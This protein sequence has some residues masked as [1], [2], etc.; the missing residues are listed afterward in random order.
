MEKKWRQFWSIRK[1]KLNIWIWVGRK[2][3][4]TDKLHLFWQMLFYSWNKN[5]NNKIAFMLQTM[6]QSS[7]L[8]SVINTRLCALFLST[9]QWTL[10]KLFYCS[11]VRSYHPYS[12][13]I[14]FH[15]FKWYNPKRGM[16]QDGFPLYLSIFTLLIWWL[17][18]LCLSLN[19]STAVT[20]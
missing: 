1:M 19:L 3:E 16:E 9:S 13:N 18:D 20:A 11:N 8:M 2:V 4:T 15:F 5:N 12:L 17:Y 7:L 14:S 10:I 6:Q